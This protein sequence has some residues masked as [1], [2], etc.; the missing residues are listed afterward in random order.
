MRNSIYVMGK[1]IPVSGYHGSP[2]RIFVVFPCMLSQHTRRIRERYRG[3]TSRS[4]PR[5]RPWYLANIWSDPGQI[6]GTVTSWLKAWMEDSL[7]WKTNE[8]DLWW[9]R[10]FDQRT[11]FQEDNLFWKTT[12]DA[13]WPLM[14]D[15]LWYN[16]YLRKKLAQKK[17]A[18]KSWLKKSWNNKPTLI[19]TNIFCSESGGTQ[20]KL[21]QQNNSDF[22]KHIPFLR[23]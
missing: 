18:Q 3:V 11:P 17:L 10:N 8:D 16:L 5:V 9:R 7:W 23:K 2:D 6:H 4:W 22:F 15:N 19:F 14:E 13:R 1:D 20:K 21:I 12:L